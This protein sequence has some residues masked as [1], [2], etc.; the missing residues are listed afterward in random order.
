MKKKKLFA[1]AAMS[2]EYLCLCHCQAAEKART[3]I[4]DISIASDIAAAANNFF[5]FIVLLSF[6]ITERFCLFA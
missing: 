6:I 5:F 4:T 1:A 3:M 2:L